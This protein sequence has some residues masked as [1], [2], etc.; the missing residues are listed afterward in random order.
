MTHA[1]AVAGEAGAVG[2]MQALV[3]IRPGAYML[4]F[5]GTDSG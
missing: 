2:S 4:I 5:G 1:Y 3:S